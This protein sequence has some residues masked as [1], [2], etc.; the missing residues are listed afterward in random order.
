M[1][2]TQ[3]VRIE[4][5]SCIKA[6]ERLEP[7]WRI[8]EAT[9][10]NRTVHSSF[11]W[12]FPWYRHFT[13]A[14]LAKYGQPLLGIAWQGDQLVGLAP[15]VRRE[16]RFSRVMM[17]RVDFVGFNAETGEFLITDGQPSLVGA[18]M[19]S[20]FESVKFDLVQLRGFQTNSREFVA[21]EAAAKSRHFNI[22]LSNYYYPIVNLAD[23]YDAYYKSRSNKFRRVLKRQTEKIN[24]DFGGWEIERFTNLDGEQSLRHALSRVTSIYNSSWKAVNEQ[25]LPN[26]FIAFY[27]DISTRFAANTKLDLSILSI[28]SQDAAFFLAIEDAGV[29]Y[30]VFVSYDQRFKALR[31]GEFLMKQLF[32]S[33]A[34][35]N[36]RTLVSHGA[37]QYKKVWSTDEIP[38]VRVFIF[39]RRIRALIG[40]ALQFKIRPFLKR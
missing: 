9:V 39:S 38:R 30:D 23:G 15:L 36:C 10:K 21:L 35:R 19:A 24:N 7:E 27:S 6:I 5:T 12:V 2:N 18:F 22:E 25:H 28:G 33:I 34:E 11:D 37:H 40:W 4:W 20:L 3:D 16:S 26:H 32:P 13:G 8:L 29:L 1:S 14:G 31:P 17:R